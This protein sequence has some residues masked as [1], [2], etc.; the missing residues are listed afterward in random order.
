MMTSK[1]EANYSS[2]SSAN[3]NIGFETVVTV[4]CVLNAP[5]MLLPIIGNALLLVAILRTPSIQQVCDETSQ[6]NKKNKLR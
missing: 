5:L 2:N 1:F 6:A 4:N 3:P